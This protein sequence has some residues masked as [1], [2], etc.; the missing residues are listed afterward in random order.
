MNLSPESRV[1]AGF[2]MDWRRSQ[3]A[4]TEMPLVPIFLLEA[5]SLVI[6]ALNKKGRPG[7]PLWLKC[8]VPV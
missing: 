3:T 2:S 7:N 4:A 6:K 8:Y 1:R 5:T